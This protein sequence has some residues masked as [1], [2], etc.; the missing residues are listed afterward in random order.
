MSL[1]ANK[2]LANKLLLAFAV[3]AVTVGPAWARSSDRNQAMDIEAGKQSGTF[4]DRAPAILSGGVHITQ[5]SLD[6]RSDRAEISFTG[7]DPSRAVFTGSP[8]VLKQTMDDGTPMT[9]RATHVDYNLKSETIVF[10]GNV[11]VQQP[12]GSMSGQRMVYNLKTG[13]IDSGGDG[14]GRVKMRI[15]PKSQQ[16]SSQQGKSQT[17]KN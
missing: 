14:G 12:R 1:H 16:G 6:I 11:Q 17:G 5:G 8:V 7:G 15:L 10:T 3:A 4:D 2:L 13:N 9:S